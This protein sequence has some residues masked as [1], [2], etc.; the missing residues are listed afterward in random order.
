MQKATQRLLAKALLLPKDEQQEL[1]NALDQDLKEL[2]SK[3]DSA[4]WTEFNQMINE[5]VGAADRAG[6]R[7]K[8]DEDVPELWHSSY[9]LRQGYHLDPSGAG[10][11]RHWQGG[12]SRLP[13][14]RCRNCKKQ[15]LLIWDI[16]CLDPRFRREYAGVFRNLSRLPLM[17]CVHC[18]GPT[19]YQCIDDEQVRVIEIDANGDVSPFMDVPDYLPRKPLNLRA[20]PPH[21]ENLLLLCDAVGA[22][23]LHPSDKK[24]LGMYVGVKAKDAKYVGLHLRRSVFGGMII[25]ERGRDKQRCPNKT[26]ATHRWGH[27]IIRNE[28]FYFMKPLAIV[29]HDA[30]LEME[31]NGSSISFW[32]CWACNTVLA[33]YSCT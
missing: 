2:Q 1:S 17:Y 27:P 3:V 18:A 5:M 13:K 22:D 6:R 9:Y 28:T 26:C 12:E 33:N 4:D 19:A 11:T 32:L 31:T 10:K 25:P 16:D 20:I 23:W 14:A 7:R 21:I 15:L 8:R 24:T 30:G 29:D